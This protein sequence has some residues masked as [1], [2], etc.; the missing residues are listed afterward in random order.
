MRCTTY[1]LPCTADLAKQCQVPLA[2]IIKPFAN[3]PNNE[4]SRGFRYDLKPVALS[5]NEKVQ[6]KSTIDN[7]LLR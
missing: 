3:L 5:K 2:T 7:S 4:V 1:A 6:I